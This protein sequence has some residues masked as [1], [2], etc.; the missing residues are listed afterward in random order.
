MTPNHFTCISRC[1]L[2]NVI[3]QALRLEADAV[4]A[5]VLLTRRSL[6]VQQT[7]HGRRLAKFARKLG[8]A[9]AGVFVDAVYASAAVLMSFQHSTIMI[10]YRFNTIIRME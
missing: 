10:I 4:L 1:A 7:H 3:R 2:A 6:W 8:R 5:I 9:L